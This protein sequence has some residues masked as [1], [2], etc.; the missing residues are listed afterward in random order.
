MRESIRL[1]TI[2]HCY[3]SYAF[4]P[5][6]DVDFLG[7]YWDEESKNYLD[8][9]QIEGL[10]HHYKCQRG[11]FLSIFAWDMCDAF[12]LGGTGDPNFN[13]KK[14]AIYQAFK[15]MVEIEDLTNTEDLG[16]DYPERLDYV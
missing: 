14:E 8:F 1:K 6:L 7:T 13:W 3:Q 9:Y 4:K 2:S 12:V 5:A 11:K 15:D 10:D 16:Q